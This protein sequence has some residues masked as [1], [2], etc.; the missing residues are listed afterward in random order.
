MAGAIV[1]LWLLVGGGCLPGGNTRYTVTL[2]I[3]IGFFD[4]FTRYIYPLQA[5]AGAVTRE[6]GGRAEA[7]S[8]PFLDR[9]WE[10]PWEAFGEVTG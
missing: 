9:P 7:G 4:D 5:V 3:N 2:T 10:N 8:A 6:F 1:N